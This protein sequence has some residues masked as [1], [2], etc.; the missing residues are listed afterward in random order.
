VGS[1]ETNH[2]NPAWNREGKQTNRQTKSGEPRG[3]RSTAT[4]SLTCA[5][6]SLLLPLPVREIRRHCLLSPRTRC[7]AAVSSPR[8]AAP[9]ARP[10][11]SRRAKS[12]CCA[13]V[14]AGRWRMTRGVPALPSLQRTAAVWPPDPKTVTSPR[15]ACSCNMGAQPRVLAREDAGRPP[16]P[17]P[18]TRAAGRERRME[19]CRKERRWLGWDRERWMVFRVAD[20]R[21][22]SPQG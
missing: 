5:R 22:H 9:L 16:C 1:R 4:A 13:S 11:L 17:S 10:L 12:V 15:G 14:G 21:C 19:N 18:R 20:L 3:A 7:R 2:Q 6:E 8:A